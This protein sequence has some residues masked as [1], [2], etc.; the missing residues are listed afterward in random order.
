MRS[1]LRPTQVIIAVCVL[2][3]AIVT[4]SSLPQPYPTWPT[5][6]SIPISPELVVPG[7]LG[8]VTVGRTVRD[9]VTVGSVLL[10]ILAIITLWLAATSLSALYTSTGGGVFF[11][12]LF[13]LLSGITLA[14]GVLVQ[15][16]LR[17]N[18]SREV[19]LRVQERLLR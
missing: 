6:G 3:I 13:T 17:R 16:I 18:L 19:S 1:L 4:F 8:L 14:V 11:G 15:C 5:V 2:L 10:G 12:G 9:G 7:L